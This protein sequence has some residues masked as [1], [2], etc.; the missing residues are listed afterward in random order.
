M[1]ITVA[2]SRAIEDQ[3]SA[4]SKTPTRMIEIV[5]SMPDFVS[6]KGFRVEDGERVSAPV[7]Q[8]SQHTRSRNRKKKTRL[9]ATCRPVKP[10]RMGF[11]V[12]GI[13]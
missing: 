6:V 8:L 1:P 9:G 7:S 12:P 13:R 3:Y 10:F 2:R 11:L 5:K 4:Y